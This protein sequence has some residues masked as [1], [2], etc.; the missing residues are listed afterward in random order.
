M[1]KAK[2]GSSSSTRSGGRMRGN[3]RLSRGTPSRLT[4]TAAVA[5]HRPTVAAAVRVSK[6]LR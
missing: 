2:G 1:R 4:T 3:A 5:G 6:P